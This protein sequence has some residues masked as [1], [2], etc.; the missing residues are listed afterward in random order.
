MHPFKG[1]F[2]GDGSDALVKN[3]FLHIYVVS[4]DND[5]F[6]YKYIG[7]LHTVMA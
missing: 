7:A 2:I 3:T 1:A 6:L 5:R 4:L